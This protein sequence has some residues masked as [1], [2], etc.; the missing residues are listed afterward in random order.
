MTLINGTVCEEG[1]QLEEQQF[2]DQKVIK[3]TYL[4][5]SSWGP[6]I[7]TWNHPVYQISKVSC[8]GV[9][10]SLAASFMPNLSANASV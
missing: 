6:G 1:C 2:Q 8:E 9:E 5:N 3:L 7:W 4:A 10:R